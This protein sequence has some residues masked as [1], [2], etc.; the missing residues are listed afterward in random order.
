[1]AA[2][3]ITLRCSL[4]VAL[5]IY[6]LNFDSRHTGPRGHVGYPIGEAASY[7]GSPNQASLHRGRTE[8]SSRLNWPGPMGGRRCLSCAATFRG[9]L[10]VKEV[11]AM[12]EMTRLGS[13]PQSE[14]ELIV[15]NVA[16]TP[17][18]HEDG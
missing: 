18:G 17:A 9:R 12:S 2:S 7:R 16:S 5:P 13:R 14:A 3:T 10:T 1:M 11:L 8:H 15:L 4:Q 6:E